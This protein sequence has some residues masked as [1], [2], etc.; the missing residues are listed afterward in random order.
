MKSASGFV[1]KALWKGM[2]SSRR[3]S[4]Q[5]GLVVLS[6]RGLAVSSQRLSRRSG[7]VHSNADE[8]LRVSS[9][10]EIDPIDGTGSVVSRA[11]LVEKELDVLGEAQADSEGEAPVGHEVGDV[12]G[13][14]VDVEGSAGLEQEEPSDG[15][16]HVGVL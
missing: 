9:G 11:S 16:Q 3:S 13:Q 4:W 14:L 10:L 6:S 12:P 5:S 2:G 1:R 8:S 7:L 15:M